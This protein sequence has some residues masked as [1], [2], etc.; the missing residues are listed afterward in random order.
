MC[1]CSTSHSPLQSPVVLHWGALKRQYL[2]ML[3][4]RTVTNRRSPAL[5]TVG[6]QFGFHQPLNRT[7][8]NLNVQEACHPLPSLFLHNRSQKKSRI[9]DP[10]ILLSSLPVGPTVTLTLTWSFHL[11]SQRFLSKPPRSLPMTV[12]DCSL[13]GGNRQM[14]LFKSQSP[15]RKECPFALFQ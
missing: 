5:I 3:N 10:L 7:D 6:N 4:A 2:R 9:W 1:A 11:K 14:V 13:A 12:P 15:L 8:A